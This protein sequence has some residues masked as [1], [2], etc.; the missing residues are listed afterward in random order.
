MKKVLIT[1]I[2]GL[3]GGLL[4]RQLVSEGGYQLTGLNRR[5]VEGVKSFQGNVANLDGIRPAFEGVEVVVHLAAE[6]PP[7]EW[8]KQLSTNIIGTYNVYEAA[9]LAGV[10]RVVFASSGATVNGFETIHPYDKIV[11]GRFE[12]VPQPFDKVTHEMLRPDG[13]YGVAKA[14]GESLGRHFSD[15]Y[16][17]SVLC[18]RIGSVRRENCP[19]NTREFAVYLSHR[20]VVQIICKCINAPESLLYD[21]FLATSDNKWGWRDLEHPKQV[22]GYEPK[23]TSDVFV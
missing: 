18:I 2:S 3:I 8:E 23:D 15:E 20:D 17:L 11:E 5:L 9:R 19:Q 21:V 16:G 12:E 13:I 22:L 6:L 10:K 1:G 14:W 7:T 4:K